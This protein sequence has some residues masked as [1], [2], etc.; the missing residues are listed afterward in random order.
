[1]V[2][3]CEQITG[4][5]ILQGHG[6]ARPLRIEFAGAL[7]HVT[8]RGNAQGDISTSNEQREKYL[9]LLAKACK[10]FD[11]YWHACCQMSNH[12]HLLIETNT[13]TLSKGV[14]Y[15]NGSYAIFQRPE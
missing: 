2:A 13:P 14:K 10:R 1:M 12:Y 9:E 11:W 8:A 5:K 15:L 4:E 6:M 7:Y 3:V